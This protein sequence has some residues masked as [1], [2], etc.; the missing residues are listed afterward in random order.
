MKVLHIIIYIG[1]VIGLLHISSCTGN[2]NEQPVSRLDSLT[3]DNTLPDTRTILSH[4]K[5]NADLVTTE[6]TIRKIVKYDSS[7]SEHVELLNPTTWK[8]GD[9]K[10]IVPIEVTIEYGYDMN[11]M[12]IDNIKLTDDST[13]VVIELPKAKIVNAGYNMMI[14]KGSVTSFTTGLRDAIGHELEEALRKKGYEAVMKEDL[15][16]VVGSDIERNAKS[17]FES[18]VKS[19]GYEN[20]TIVVTSKKR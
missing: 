14:E 1:A 6:V 13:A 11:E 19:L 4:L 17:V 12:G 9:R 5:Q 15:S 7:Q 2:S 10:C 8:V 3:A 16:S 18:I 20:V